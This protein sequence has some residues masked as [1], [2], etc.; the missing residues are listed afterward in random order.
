M[1]TGRQPWS[2][3]ADVAGAAAMLSVLVVVALWVHSRGLQD[4]GSAAPGLSSLGRLTGLVSADLLLLQVLLMARVPWV[5]RSFGQD[6]LARWHRWTG[7]TSFHLM[8]AHI[9]LI[10]IGYA[11]SDHAGVLGELWRL[12]VTYPGMLLAAAASVALTMVV[13]SSVRAAR[14][15]LRYESW[16]LLHL[17][18]YLGVGLALPHELWTGTDFVASAPARA[19]WWTL[20]L[21]AAGGLVLFRLGLPA[22]RTLRH[23]PVVAAVVPEGPGV[24]SVHLRGRHLDRLPAR[25]GQF[26]LWRFLDGPGWSRANPYSLS[27]APRPDRLRLTVKDLGEGSRRVAT[28]RPGTR[29]IVEGP[30]GRMT[31][32]PADGRPVTMLAS[33]VGITPLRALLDEIRAP[34]TLLYRARAADDLVFA[35]ELDAAVAA[36]RLRIGYLVGPRSREG[37]WVPAGFRDDQLRRWVPGIREHHVFVCGPDAWMRA[38]SAAVLDAGVPPQRLHTERFNW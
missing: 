36:G 8:L 15:R 18:A 9:V 29:V 19:Y 38:A 3:W 32:P 31:A 30:Y 11:A 23:R 24:F 28:L 34:V 7:F 33:G 6:R 35:A 2:G 22:W 16:H 13:V 14:R 5:E 26:F 25:A 17:Y 10:T 27:A 21:G 37:S 20:Y 12:V 1:R 4:L